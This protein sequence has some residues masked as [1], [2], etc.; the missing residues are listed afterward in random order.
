MEEKRV[1]AT[2]SKNIP[3]YQLKKLV[4]YAKQVFLSNLMWKFLPN[5]WVCA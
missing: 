3:S 5:T 4:M 1:I 2:G